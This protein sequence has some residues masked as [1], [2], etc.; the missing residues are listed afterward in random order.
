M[1]E[2]KTIKRGI[3]IKPSDFQK[4]MQRCQ[5]K[6]LNFNQWIN[7]AISLGLRKH[8]TPSPERTELKN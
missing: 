4:I 7:W 1:G 8:S 3:C 5:K 6:G 2:R